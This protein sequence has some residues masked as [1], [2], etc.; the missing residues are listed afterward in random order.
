MKNVVKKLQEARHHIKSSNMKK[1]G[2]NKFSKYSYFTPEQINILVAHA[3]KENTLLHKFDLMQDEYGY[4]GVLEI[5]DYESGESVKFYQRTAIPEMKATN[6]TQQ[7]G[8]SVT[9]TNRYMLMTAYD[10]VE[11]EDD[12]DAQDNRPQV[13]EKG[14]LNESLEE[15]KNSKSKES[16]SKTWNHVWFKEWDENA[17]GTLKT[18]FND[19][20]KEFENQN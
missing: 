5:I 17:T 3:E 4:L 6:I 19:K 20:L 8:G 12:F 18:A 10:I 11:N 1:D 14:N 15:I 9:Y 13:K 16:M 2:Q 7:M